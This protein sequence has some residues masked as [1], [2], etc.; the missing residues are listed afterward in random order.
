MGE[1]STSQAA[2]GRGAAD[3]ARPAGA[4]RFRGSPA[5]APPPWD[6]FRATP[7]AVIVMDAGGVVRDW[8]PAAEHIFGY[9]RDRAIGRTVAELVIP[10][11]LRPAHRNALGRYLESGES[12]VLDRRLEVAA[13]RSDGSEFSVEI[14]VTRLAD[15]EPPLFAGFVRDLSERE[16][17]RLERVQQR[18][19]F[20]AR[21]GLVLDRSLDY[22]ET[23]QGLAALTVPELAQL[24][25]IDL[26]EDA[27]SIRTAV[28]CAP[29]PQHARAVEAI[30]RDHPLDLASAHPVAAVLRSGEP[31][32]VPSMEIEYQREIA[33]GD[34]HFELMRRLRYHSAIVVPL[35]ARQRVLGTLSLLRMEGARSYDQ[36]DLALA[37]DL[38]R[39]AALAVDNARL[40]QSTQQLARTLQES[41]LP[42]ALP[43]IPGIHMVGRYR[44]A[45]QGQDVG[46]D[47][48][49]AFAI[50]ENRWGIVIGDVCGKGAQAGAL[51]ALARYTIRALADRDAA[52]VL[53][54]LNDAVT[55]D[56]DFVR[57]RFLTALMIV[58]SADAGHLHLEMAAAGHPA[59]LVLR[60]DATVEK[61]SVSGPLIG[62]SHEAEYLSRNAVLHPG[63]TMLLYTDGLTD[64]RAPARILT[65]SDLA[66]ILVAAHGMGAERLAAFIE[67]QAIAGEDPRDDIAIL[68][69]E[70]AHRS[71][72][73]A[74]R[75]VGSPRAARLD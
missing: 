44:A 40:F 23:L 12:T 16:V 14:T 56:Q 46:G 17:I 74:T 62:V 65:D 39:R 57:E 53:G 21:A 15:L 48:Y 38:A 61:L 26:L 35:V 37:E 63:D 41:L 68:V 22:D 6:V 43:Q 45:A 66:E 11:P 32:L 5:D 71:D 9:S 59:P 47:F 42:Q 8:N 7:D 34:E 28:A 29:E 36:D 69:I 13:L 58:A 18:M 19:T 25:V 1:L 2:A 30:R 33:T 60:R 52:T 75:H 73:H 3:L 72:E 55:R 50:G 27:G 10:V 54:L 20:L 4:E 67:E 31:M 51:T 64:A 49:D 70:L 24:T